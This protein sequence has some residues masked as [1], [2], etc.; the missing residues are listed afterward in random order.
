MDL[1]TNINSYTIEELFEILGNP[2]TIQEIKAKSGYYM[3]L[4]TTQGNDK[5]FTFFKK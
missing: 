4:Y 5:L 1:D 2:E 3:N